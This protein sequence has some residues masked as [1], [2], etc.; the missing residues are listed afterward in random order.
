MPAID[1]ILKNNFKINRVRKKTNKFF[2]YSKS[3][4][5]KVC[6]LLILINKKNE[7]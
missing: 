5:L 3:F 4:N 2:N 7:D 6:L 1:N